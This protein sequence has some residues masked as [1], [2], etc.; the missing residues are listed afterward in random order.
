MKTNIA[1]GVILGLLTVF[2][3]ACGGEKTAAND[4][5]RPGSLLIVGGALRSDNSAVYQAFIDAIPR[6][7]PNVAIVPVASGRPAHYA[8]QFSED[9]RHYGFAGDIRVLPI[10]VLDDSSTGAV[11]ESRWEAGGRD[12][13]VADSLGDVGGIWFVG[14]DQTRITGA[15]FANGEVDTPVLEAIRRQLSRGAVVGGTSAGAAIM[16]RTMIAAGDSLSAL[17]MPVADQ[18]VGMETQE[19]GQLMLAT[20]LGFL[21]EGIVDQ[22]FDRKARLGRLVRALGLMEDPADRIGFGVDEDTALLV[23]L[24]DADITVLGAGNLVVADGRLAQFSGGGQAF[25]AQGVQLSVLSAGDRYNWRTGNF[26]LSGSE[27]QQNEAFGYGVVQGAGIAL[28]NQRLDELLGFSLLDNEKAREVRRFS[29]DSDSGKGVLF[30]F[31]Q[32]ESSRGFWRYRS[33]TKDQ[34]SIVGVELD[35][36]PVSVTIAPRP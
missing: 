21:P 24:V 35:I 16:S 3:A 34:Y 29:F 23:D 9:L 20:G 32:T 11:D 33:G 36:A 30:H 6:Q 2:I 12:P 26:E 27:T 17:T 22:H 8:E 7:F 4:L 25:A 31:R 28:G 13:A 1:V 19:S 15:L 18:Y 10:A 14:G 5:E